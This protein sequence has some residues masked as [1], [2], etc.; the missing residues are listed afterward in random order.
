MYLAYSLIARECSALSKTSF[1]PGELGVAG[2]GDSV[3]G[4]GG[5]VTGVGGSVAGGGDGV[6]GAGGA[7]AG[8][9]GGVTGVGGMGACGV[10]VTGEETLTRLSCCRLLPD[11]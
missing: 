9:G 2:V 4:A 1:V 5:G 7:G 11:Q 6:T 3:A 10:G 8:V